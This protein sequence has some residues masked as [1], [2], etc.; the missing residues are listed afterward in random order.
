MLMMA[1][2]KG[3]IPL[4]ED[5]LAPLLRCILCRSC[6]AN[7][8]SQVPYAQILTQFRQHFSVKPQNSAV[9]TMMNYVQAPQKYNLALSMGKLAQRTGLNQLI[10]KS[11]IMQEQVKQLATILPRL[12]DSEKIKPRYNA[13][14][15][16]GNV[17]L[18]KG[19]MGE[20]LDSRSLKDAIKLLT[21]LGYC[22]D[23]PTDL[24]C[25]GAM[26]HHNGDI[27]TSKQMLKRNGDLFSQHHYSAIV[28]TSSA[29]IAHL[30][31]HLPEKD[32][33]PMPVMDI[34]EFL[35]QQN[36]KSLSFKQHKQSIGYHE[37]CSNRNLLKDNS[38]I[39]DLFLHFPWIELHS[40]EGNSFCC[41]AGGTQMI[42]NKAQTALL[43]Q[44]RI[45]DI[46]KHQFN[47]VISQNLSCTLNLVEGLKEAGISTDVVH[48][49]SLIANM[50]LD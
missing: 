14:S 37:T 15:S 24:Q 18:F 29:C 11:G 31:E 6:E 43:R 9:K 12:G 13:N 44:S 20:S 33:N 32:N 17:L 39:V 5:S 46:A 42:I 2:A 35:A 48:P 8:P 27:Q 16:K 10:D 25:C 3:N 26:H 34:V 1:V 45:E 36:W 49:V 21:L 4:D 40:L 23:I 38:A 28:G 7:C 41:G 22:V 19:C 30:K 50:V 47:A